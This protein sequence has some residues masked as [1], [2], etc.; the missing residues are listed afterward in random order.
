MSTSLPFIH[1][2]FLLDSKEAIDLYHRYAKNQPIIDYH[3][4]LSPQELAENKRWSNIAQI[5]LYGDHYK[6]RAMRTAGVSEVFCTGS[7]SD[8][9]K[10]N[11][12]AEIT[13]LLLRNPLYHWS[14][15]ELKSYFGISDLLLSAQTAPQIWKQ[16]NQILQSPDFSAWSILEKSKVEV[17]CTTDDPIDSLEHHRKIQTE[18]KCPAQVFP[19]WRP[20]KVL[21]V[22]RGNPFLS[23]IKSLSTVS[24]VE[25]L[26]LQS[27]L[28]A[29]RIRHDFFAQHG[30]KLSDRG[31]ETVWSLE[32][33]RTEADAILKK[34]LEGTPISPLESE[35]YKSLMLH[36]LAVMDAEKGWTMQIHYGALRNNNTRLFKKIGPDAGFDS[37][38]DWPIAESLSKHLDR[39]DAMERL[40]RTILYNLN[41]R[42]FEMIGTMIGNFQDGTIA[43]KLQMGSGWWFMDQLDGMKRQMEALSQLGLL[44][45]FVGMLTDSRSFLSYTRHEYFRRLLCNLLGDEMKRGLL[46]QDPKLI[47]SLVEKVSYTNAKNYFQF[48]NF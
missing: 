23:W 43:G 42:D 25:V 18:G 10:F 46:P 36:E 33:T 35:K 24:G 16:A 22:D 45:C 14:H 30:C 40:P 6:W 2:N 4:H 15:L 27:L 31:I 3:C 44:S 1:D 5:W 28:T 7:A 11:Q 9:E 19:T 41:P 21:W 39:L 26:D 34:A 12:F 38:G 17:I 37:I 32:C 8:E 48:G 20:D 47:G 13:P 29:L